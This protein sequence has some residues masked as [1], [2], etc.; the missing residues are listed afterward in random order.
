[1]K[2]PLPAD[3][4]NNAHILK[5][6]F[7]IY[8]GARYLPLTKNPTNIPFGILGLCTSGS[9]VVNVYLSEL[10]LSKG[11]LLVI[12]PGELAS[13]KEK[14]EDFCMDYFIVSSNLI[15]DTLSGIPHLSPLFFMHMRRKYSY[16]LSSEEGLRYKDYYRLVCERDAPADDIYLREY[17]VNILRLFYLDLYNN[18]RNTLFGK[19][20]TIAA[21]KERLTYDFFLLLMEYCRKNREIAFY[22]DKLFIT[23]K[24]LALIIKE[25]SGRSA[26]DWIVEYIILEIKSLLKNSQLNIQE[27]TVKTSF[28][29]QASL[30]RF[31]RKHTGMSPSEYR[32]K[33]KFN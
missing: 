24:Y 8:E 33:A 25:V 31:F 30:G 21:R 28:S 2:R 18:Y 9:V 14:S 22:A 23:P 12:L 29:N 32:L 19:D 5:G 13:I 1:M 20:K 16:N 3:K 10:Y 7:E 6:D 17:L 11:Q 27:I 15:N 4:T 26:K